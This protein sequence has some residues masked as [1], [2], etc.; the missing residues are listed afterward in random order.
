MGA[1]EVLILAADHIYAM[2]FLPLLASHRANRAM[3][4]VAAMPVPVTDAHRFGIVTE[5]RGG[6]MD[7][8]HEKPDLPATMPDDPES[9]L[10]SLGIYVVDW[11]WLKTLLQNPRI[12]DFG[13]DVI[14]LAVNQG[15]AALWRWSG[16]WRDVGT[17]DSLRES[18]LDF[19]TGSTPCR[20]PLVPEMTV[21]PPQR[22]RD[23]FHA[24]A[25]MGGLRL[26]SPLIDSW[27]TRRWAAL[28]RSILM[29]GAQIGPGVRL[30]NVIAA[31]GTVIAD[32]MRIGEDPVEDRR[33]FRLSGD[34]TLV[35][36]AMLARRAALR[37]RSFS[38][39]PGRPAL[40]PKSM[41]TS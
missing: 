19:E 36:P 1:R 16:Y 29:T 5:G 15:D 38:L 30:T 26:L 23:R 40:V 13:H 21:L 9:S 34:T 39:F 14:P 27:D 25:D 33:W 17:L 7:A 28:D 20:R 3:V 22:I 8:F 32:G 41:R 10:A 24:R 12:Q 6:K 37:E 35:T 18:W 4:T 31:P 11:H 2:D